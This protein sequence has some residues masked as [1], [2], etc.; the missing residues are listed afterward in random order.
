MNLKIL[1]ELFWE[2]TRAVAGSKLPRFGAA[3]AYYTLFSIAPLILIVLAIAGFWFGRETA[4]HEL[5]SQLSQL[6]GHRGTEA[7]KTLM[8][9]ANKPKTGLLATTIALAM[10]FIG[11]SSVFVELQDALNTVWNVKRRR[12]GFW[13]FIRTRLL[14]FAMVLGIGF[15][16]MVSLV[17]S[18]VLAVV[19]RYMSGVIPGNEFVWTIIDYIVSLGIITV[20][21]A[22]IFKLLPDA[23]IA[24]RDVWVGA[25]VTALLFNFGK[26][27]LGF[28]LGKSGLASIYGATGSLV[29]FLLWVYYSAQIL[30][31]GAKYTQ[32]YADKCGSRVESSYQTEM[33]HKHPANGK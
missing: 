10:L 20:L 14:S 6:I 24:W 22:L 28:Y 9:A 31:F 26:F 17:L 25:L 8:A 32:L 21:F 27:L 15:L 33:A 4:Q 2:T 3:L 5:F 19:S 12:Q 23:K 13:D 11:A 1:G 29:I 18:T 7:I 30:L 16:L